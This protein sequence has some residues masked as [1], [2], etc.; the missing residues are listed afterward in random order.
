VNFELN[1]YTVGENESFVEVCAVLTPAA[2]QITTVLIITTE[3]TARG[4]QD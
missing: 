2:S 1:E 3:V 4:D